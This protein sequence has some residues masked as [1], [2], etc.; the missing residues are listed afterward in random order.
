M[1]ADLKTQAR[2]PLTDAAK[3]AI[4]VDAKNI[5]QILGQ[6]TEEFSGLVNGGLSTLANDLSTAS[7]DILD[8]RHAIGKDIGSYRWAQGQLMGE[9]QAEES[10]VCPD[11]STIAELQQKIGQLMAYAG[12]AGDWESTL[13]TV[14]DLAKEAVPSARFLQS[15]WQGIGKGIQQASDAAKKVPQDT[16]AVLSLDLQQIQDTWTGVQQEMQKITKQ[17][18]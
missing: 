9:L 1:I 10:K 5:V 17:L 13:T 4:A 7:G 14:C 15:F 8:C 2:P 16:A 6:K 12:A 18:P 3:K 11:K